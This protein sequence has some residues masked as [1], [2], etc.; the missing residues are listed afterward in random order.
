MSSTR[1]LEPAGRPLTSYT[2]NPHISYC[3][4][5]RE[6]PRSS[7]YLNNPFHEHSLVINQLARRLALD[8]ILQGV[9]ITES[10]RLDVTKE[11]GGGI[12]FKE[13]SVASLS[14]Q[15]SLRGMNDLGILF[16]GRFNSFA[17]CGL[18]GLFLLDPGRRRRRLA[19]GSDHGVTLAVAL[20]A[21]LLGLTAILLVALGLLEICRK[22]AQ[23]S[24]QQP[25]NHDNTS[26]NKRN[27]RQRGRG[28]SKK[29]YRNIPKSLNLGNTGFFK[30]K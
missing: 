22:S 3:A 21:I 12:M 10:Q 14:R 23:H 1:F 11:P 18:S 20:D 17:R 28:K 16:K 29:D 25:Q 26:N 5:A 7:T 27:R 2:T 4:R 19:D 6:K 30:S 24:V 13:S 9:D 8:E 15:G